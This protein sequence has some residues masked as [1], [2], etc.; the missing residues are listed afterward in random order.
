MSIIF[1]PVVVTSVLVFPFVFL[2]S[3]ILGCFMNYFAYGLSIAGT[4]PGV[5]FLMG[6]ILGAMVGFDM[7]GPINKIAV[8]TGSCLIAVDPRI[9]GACAA[10]IPVAPLGCGLATLI[11]RKVFDADERKVGVTAIALG[12]MGISE[13][14]IPMFSKKPKQTLIANVAGSAVAGGLAFFFFC[15]GHVSM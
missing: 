3:G 15:G 2:L 11:F 6:F 5:N 8:A 12:T 1:I 7:G 4:T 14:A 10:A 13:G 9:M